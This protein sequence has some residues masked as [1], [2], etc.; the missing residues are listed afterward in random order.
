MPLVTDIMTSAGV[1][2]APGSDFGE[3]CKPFIRF[4]FARDVDVV[5]EGVKRLQ[6]YFSS[7]QIASYKQ[8]TAQSL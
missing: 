1:A 7:K 4:C 3:S 5:R 6:S 2:M 8:P